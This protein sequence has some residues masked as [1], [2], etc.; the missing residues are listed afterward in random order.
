MDNML[1]MLQEASFNFHFTPGLSWLGLG[2]FVPVFVLGKI[3]IKPD[4]RGTHSAD[5]NAWKE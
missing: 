4:G 3:L 2:S 1:S 5:G